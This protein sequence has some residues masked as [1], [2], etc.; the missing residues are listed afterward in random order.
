MAA[1]RYKPVDLNRVKT[2]SVAKRSHRVHLDAV[3]G[4]PSPGASARELLDS[5]PDFLGARALGA[6][7]E[8]VVSAVKADRPVVLAMGAHV[9]KVGCSPIVND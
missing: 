2:Y 6:V 9:V 4:T 7:V 3:A 1:A 5:L 8:A